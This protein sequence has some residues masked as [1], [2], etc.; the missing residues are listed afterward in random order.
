MKRW[1]LTIGAIVGV[2]GLLLSLSINANAAGN[3]KDEAA[4]KDIENKLIAA[5]NTDE[6]MKYYDQN[7]IDLFDFSG[8]PLQYQGA[9]AVHGDLDGFFNNA[10]NVKGSFVEMVV[11]TDGKLGIVRSI[12][13]FTYNDKDGKAQEATIRV[14]DVFHKTGGKWKVIHSHVSVPVD[15]KTGQG[16]MNLKS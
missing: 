11:V 10:K 13:H 14:T 5:T 16:Q 1:G 9:T 7:D 15:P 4:L 12:Q 3:A 8:P 2:A 6:V